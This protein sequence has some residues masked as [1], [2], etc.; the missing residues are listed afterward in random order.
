M[1]KAELLINDLFENPEVFGTG[2]LA[3][4][5]LKEF[6]RGFPVERLRKLLSC[7]DQRIVKIGMFIASEL[8]NKVAP[9]LCDIVPMLRHF[10]KWVRADAIDCVLACAL[11]CNGMEIASVIAL[12]NDGEAGVR[13]KAMGFLSRASKEQLKA[14]YAH[15]VGT[16]PGSKHIRGLEFLINDDAINPDD[17]IA[18]IKGS[19]P[20]LRKYA[21]IAAV[22]MA[23][24]NSEPLRVATFVDDPDV[25]EFAADM[26]KLM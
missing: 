8:G 12:M 7:P 20:F 6:H 26:L 5:L 25:K 21:A 15:L 23:R 13:W 9:L 18:Y 10:E 14:A 17:L 1:E 16:E 2:V 3:N 4:E 24:R 11:P 22:R 19:E